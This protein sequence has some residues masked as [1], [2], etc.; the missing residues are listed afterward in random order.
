MDWGSE[1]EGKKLSQVRRIPSENK[2]NWCISLQTGKRL[3][4]SMHAIRTEEL[5]CW[6]TLWNCCM[7]KQGEK[8]R[9]KKIVFIFHFNSKIIF[10]CYFIPLSQSSRH[11]GSRFNRKLRLEWSKKAS[12]ECCWRPFS[13][14]QR[15]KGG[16][17][18]LVFCLERSTP[19]SK[20]CGTIICSLQRP[21]ATP[22]T[23][24]KQNQLYIIPCPLRNSILWFLS[25]CK[26]DFV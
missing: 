11:L 13:G 5:I 3:H 14:L 18:E 10:P 16:Q 22:T 8:N 2:C 7:A 17:R 12:P 26:L 23:K 25:S 9:S 19:A 24:P 21:P 1:L 15:L 4:T 20:I 6:N